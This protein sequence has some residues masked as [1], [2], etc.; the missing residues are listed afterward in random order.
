ML[1]LPIAHAIAMPAPALFRLLAFLPVATWASNSKSNIVIPNTRDASVNSTL[2]AD[3]FTGE[4]W[5]DLGHADNE[6]WI[7]HVTFMPSARSY[8]HR[9][10]QGQL[11]NVVAGSGWVADRNGVAQR[12][13]NG[14]TAWCPPG[15]VHWHGADSGSYL[16]HLAVAHGAT[17]WL[18]EVSDEEYERA[19]D[20]AS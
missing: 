15:I 10:K 13:H 16:V 3:T 9:H 17:E 11:L 6:T 20:Q 7:G 4:A 19:I 1:Y 12:L 14:D 8:W 18:E 5:I 2:G